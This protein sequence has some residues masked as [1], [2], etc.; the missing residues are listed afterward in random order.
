MNAVRGVTV[1]FLQPGFPSGQVLR[2]NDRIVAAG[3]LPI[4]TW[5]KLRAVIVSRDPGDEIPIS[6]VR[7]G[8]TLNLTVKLSEYGRLNQS[9]TIEPAILE[10]AWDLRSGG[11]KPPRE[12]QPAIVSTLGPADW[13]R[14]E[15]NLDEIPAADYSGGDSARTG[16]VAGGEPRGGKPPRINAAT[17]TRNFNNRGAP[18]GPF[19]IPR[20]P[21]VDAVQLQLQLQIQ[22]F[23]RFQQQRESFAAELDANNRKLADASLPEAERAKLRSQNTNLVNGIR[24]L[25]M[26]MQTIQATIKQLQQQ[27]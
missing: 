6:V 24:I 25:E 16:L 9:G 12:P 18:G 10:L 21:A 17:L 13:L 2:L 27:R 15:I 1:A 22:Q 14:P 20:Q 19:V 4:D 5:E 8:A 7:D 23:E 26:Q 11:F 3:G